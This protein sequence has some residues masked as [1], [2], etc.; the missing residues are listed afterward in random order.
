[1]GSQGVLVTDPGSLRS[2][3]PMHRATV[4]RLDGELAG[5]LRAERDTTDEVTFAG[6]SLGGDDALP[7][8]I[9]EARAAGFARVGLRT[10]A[11][12]LAEPGWLAS[13]AGAGLTDLHVPLYGASSAVHD[14]HGGAGSFDALSAA[15]PLARAARV[16]VVVTSPLTRSNARALGELPTWL[17]ARAVSA[18]A[19]S[20][21]RTG[22]ARTPAFD[23]VFPRL[24]LSLPYA[25]HAVEQ[26]MRIALPA[27]I[28]GA[29]W[30]LLGPYSARSLPDEPRAYGPMCEGCA[31][32]ARC[33]GV[34][35]A[36]LARFGGDELSP[37]RASGK[38]PARAGARESQLARML[39]GAFD[40]PGL[41]PDCAGS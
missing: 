14:Y 17:V 7:G 20:I 29:P 10:D 36:Y 9:A 41:A 19:V 18:W 23:R 6:S 40:P 12:R 13:L 34:D 25:L 15:L 24:A 8:A 1:M 38:L 16:T 30:C 2:S 39:G 35:P 33:P 28:R 32:R 5:R 11:R 21:P 4:T 22:G 26:A 3:A 27:W 37:T 31:V